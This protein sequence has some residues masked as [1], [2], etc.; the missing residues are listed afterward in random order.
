MTNKPATPLEPTTAVP[1]VPLGASAALGLGG[2]LGLAPS[3]RALSSFIEGCSTPIAI[4]IQGD[5]GTGKTSLMNLIDQKLVPG[6]LRGSKKDLC[7]S[8]KFNTWQY[9]QFSNANR[10]GISLLRS[11]VHQIKDLPPK[12][13]WLKLKPQTRAKF[14]RFAV[15]LAKATTLVA[16]AAVGGRFG[17]ASFDGGEMARAFEDNSHHIDEAHLFSALKDDFER[18]VDDTLEHLLKEKVIRR[19]KLVIYVDDLDRLAP[20]RAIELLETIKNFLDVPGCVFVLAIDYEVIVRGLRTRKGID[21]EKMEGDEGKSFFDKIIQVPFRMPTT[22]YDTGGF[23]RELYERLHGSKLHGAKSWTPFLERDAKQLID[24]TVGANPRSIKRLMNLHSLLCH[25]TKELRIETSTKSTRRVMS[26]NAVAQLFALTAIQMKWFLLYRV[27]ANAGR[28][29]DLMLIAIMLLDP[30]DEFAF[31]AASDAPPDLAQREVF[32]RKL[33]ARARSIPTQSEGQ[34][35][36]KSLWTTRAGEFSDAIDAAIRLIRDLRNAGQFTNAARTAIPALAR[37]MF[38]AVDTDGN[39]VF[40]P[41]ERTQLN[42]VLQIAR[43]VSVEDTIREPQEETVAPRK[44]TVTFAELRAP[45]P[46]GLAPF[47]AGDDPLR[48]DHSTISRELQAAALQPEG[49]QNE[50]R[51]NGETMPLLS[52]TQEI[53]R[54]ILEAD[55]SFKV[56]ELRGEMHLSYWVVEGSDGPVPL[57]SL[58]DRWREEAARLAESPG[59][60]AETDEDETPADPDCVD[61]A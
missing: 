36:S 45:R 41:K 49:R 25:L 15:G 8:I 20:V 50:S 51:W 13:D 38:Q 47:L 18:I 53:L 24:L 56:P 14:R 30:I 6:G 2:T 54:E 27:L 52:I 37:L 44:H 3:A 43:A 39:G 26:A 22:A 61:E 10:L 19:K 12:D 40:D 55:P 59:I 60:D 31:D 48:F 57:A 29:V 34:T 5:W 23:V 42:R 9:S 46:G 7:A 4:G 32:E 28:Q 33:W 17:G 1:D 11:L 16:G 35:L 58:V 21:G